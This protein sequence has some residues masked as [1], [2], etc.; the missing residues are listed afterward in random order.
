M[1]KSIFF[2]SAPGDPRTYQ[3]S[4]FAKYF[5]EVLST[6][7]LHTD[8]LPALNV[9][10]TGVDMQTYVVP[11]KA[12]ME[13]YGYENTTDLYLEHGLPESSL[14]RIDRIVLRLDKRNQ[15]RF[16][17]L[18]V[19]Q[20]LSDV[21]PVPPDLQRDEY[22][23]E[24]SLA[25]IRIRANTS[26]LQ[27]VDLVDERFDQVLCGLVSSLISV[28]TS[29]FQE[30]WDEWFKVTETYEQQFN[31]WFAG[32]QS[33]GFVTQ[34]EFDNELKIV[35][36]KSEILGIGIN[37]IVSA[38]KTPIN[39]LSTKGKTLVNYL[40]P[41]R[42]W[43][44][45]SKLTVNDDYKATLVTTTA[46]REASSVSVWY[47]KPGETYYIQGN[48]TSSNGSGG[49][50]F[51][52]IYTAANGYISTVLAGQSFIIPA[53][54]AYINFGI[55]NGVSGGFGIGTYVFEGLSLHKGTSPQ[56]TVLGVRGIVNPTVQVKSVVATTGDYTGKIAGSTLDNPHVAKYGNSTSLIT[57]TGAWTGEFNTSSYDKIN[58]LNG[59][60]G[61]HKINTNGQIGQH[62]F[63]ENLI[64]HIER[65]YK[66]KIPATNKIQWLKDNISKIVANWH[67]RGVGPN[68]YKVSLAQYNN[69]T[70]A[71]ELPKTHA[72]SSISKLVSELTIESNSVWI[73]TSGWINFIVYADPSDGT[74]ASTVETDY[75]S[76]DIELISDCELLVQSRETIQ[77][78]LHSLW[79]VSDEII[80]DNGVPRKIE[81]VRELV[82]DGG[83]PWKYTS[84]FSG[85]KIV[86]LQ[87]NHGHP[88][89]YQ[90]GFAIKFD[91][92]IIPPVPNGVPWS[93]SDQNH[94]KSDG[95]IEISIADADSGWGEAYSPT[96]DEVKAYF[97]G[98]KM[99]TWGGNAHD[100]Y[101]S[102]TKAWA[103]RA[104]DRSLYD[105]TLN[106]PTGPHDRGWENY[107]LVY[108]QQTPTIKDVSVIGNV[109][110][111]KGSNN[112]EVKAGI[113]I[114]ERANPVLNGAGDGYD[115]NNSAYSSSLLKNRASRILNVYKNG[116]IDLN[117]TVYNNSLAAIPISLFDVNAVY[118]VDYELPQGLYVKSEPVTVDY[119]QNIRSLVNAHTK[120]LGEY[121]TRFDGLDRVYARRVQDPW[122]P[123]VLQ[124]GW[125]N[126]SG[127]GNPAMYMITD[128]GYLCLRGTILNNAPGRWQ[129]ILTIPNGMRPIKSA[130]AIVNSDSGTDESVK[131]VSLQIRKDGAV[132]V[133]NTTPNRFLSL[134]NIRVPL[135]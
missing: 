77:T 57:P 93:G 1:E 124:N 120:Q 68:G 104:T 112:V 71:Y 133:H 51:A 100:P 52:D 54:A 69:N 10:C 28:P 118:F 90:N 31:D 22:I 96:T 102:G 49:R 7:L 75:F 41:F 12:L 32:Q 94:I 67:G 114:R 16:I 86:G 73:D 89:Y 108:Q 121:E 25:Q 43:T 130:I 56:Q 3:A 82:L 72:N 116:D 18:F 123:A 91:S 4:D 58:S 42:A 61:L 53:N 24:L 5:G 106:L 20:G 131:S 6:G 79:D 129:I 29:Q 45:S 62:L 126:D 92:K 109:V 37:N 115:I 55:D 99:Y 9:K 59:V 64:E 74:T 47:V 21:N 40:P 87:I 65:K 85:Y 19:K 78:V 63:S 60:V 132:M 35:N 8:N 30:Q 2:N 46:T 119:S 38:D 101:N 23:Y 107:R 66:K 111:E 83:L 110:L 76:F 84:D 36:T 88:T 81:K 44:R 98:W 14:D 80:R 127:S 97:W 34:T 13:G 26:T 103:K 128:D 122:I 11:G 134:D 117:W 50:I 33:E 27:P 15:S 39:V 48:V 135:R 95:T 70:A 113:I 17:K 105:G 125:L